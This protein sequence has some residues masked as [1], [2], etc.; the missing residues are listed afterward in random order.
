MMSRHEEPN[1]DG[2]NWGCIGSGSTPPEGVHEEPTSERC[3]G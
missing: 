1:T 2:T 3:R